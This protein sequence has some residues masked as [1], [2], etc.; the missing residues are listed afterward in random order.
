MDL[1]QKAR[2]FKAKN[3]GQL[4]LFLISEV[5]KTFIKLREVLVK[6]PILNHDNPEYY[7]PIEIDES[8]YVIIKVFSQLTFNDLN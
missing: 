7:I 3:L 1:I 4:K 8:G 2:V 5:R 6:A